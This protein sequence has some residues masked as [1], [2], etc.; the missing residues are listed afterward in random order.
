[1][2]SNVV[3]IAGYIMMVKL[4][5]L[6]LIKEQGLSRMQCVVEYLDVKGRKGIWD[7]IVRMVNKLWIG[8]SVVRIPVEARGL[9]LL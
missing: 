2:P 5:K 4:T 6:M 1:V 3:F 7:S 9:F 8:W